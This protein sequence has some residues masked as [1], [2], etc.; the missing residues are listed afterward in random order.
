VVATRQGYRR[1]SPKAAH[2]FRSRHSIVVVPAR[3]ITRQGTPVRSEDI[4]DARPS[5]AIRIERVAAKGAGK[6]NV[7]RV[8]FETVILLI[9]AFEDYGRYVDKMPL[10]CKTSSR[11]NDFLA[12]NLRVPEPTQK[13]K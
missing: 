2:T 9:E 10:S 11:G 3:N 12:S 5:Y 4:L 7:A 6:R 13:E 8:L 1:I